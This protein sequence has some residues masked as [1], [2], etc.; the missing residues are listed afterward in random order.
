MKHAKISLYTI[1]DDVA[2]TPYYRL[3]QYFDDNECRITKRAA[4]S[5]KL[6]RKWMPIS[7]KP[8]YFKVL[9]FL[10][11]YFKRLHHLFAD[12]IDTPDILIVSR[13]FIRRAMPPSYRLMLKYIMNKGTKLIWDY[14]DNII[15]CKEISRKH[16]DW[17]SSICNKIVVAG[18][19]N[20]EM[21]RE[22][23]RHKAI[24][25]PTT[26]RDM[27][28]RFCQNLIRRR[29][30]TF[31]EEI[32]LVWV[33]TSISLPYV[34]AICPA[35]ED[36]AERIRNEKSVSLA[37]VCNH[38]LKYKPTHFRLNNIQWT[39]DVAIKEM[40]KSHFG[41]MP[42]SDKLFNHYKGGF[43]LIQYLSIGLPIVGSAVGINNEIIQP[44]YGIKANALEHD[45]WV[46]ALNQLPSTI[47]EYAEYSIKAF[48]KWTECYSYETNR[49]KWSELVADLLR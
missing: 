27:Y 19:P 12:C 20:L 32:R 41:I 4:L 9:A 28:R 47:Q 2:A 42:L 45:Q 17:V 11:M 5:N 8:L 37:V 26:D 21:L 40:E 44:G 15:D 13:C 29:L 31:K 33:G 7:Q 16:F 36:F 23:H 35:V 30:D 24:I 10:H 6:Y 3:F 18:K 22:E 39:R 46:E 38:P 1:A 34:E 43:K 25:L 14:D 48:N 49:K